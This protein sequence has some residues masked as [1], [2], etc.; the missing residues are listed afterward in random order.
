ML[1]VFLHNTYIIYN[2]CDRTSR[3][4][5]VN[6]LSPLAST[7]IPGLFG[8]PFSGTDASK[9]ALFLD[10]VP[11]LR[12]SSSEWLKLS[13]CQDVS[14][15]HSK[16]KAFQLFP[17][18][19]MKAQHAPDSCRW[20]SFPVVPGPGRHITARQHAAADCSKCPVAVEV[21]AAHIRAR[22]ECIWGSTPLLSL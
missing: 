7:R 14:K 10:Y 12:S 15:F 9:I 1:N 17:T 13:A 22:I 20:L 5:V 6:F 19:S 11:S 18:L 2:S 16:Q 3:K 4:F 8:K 21:S